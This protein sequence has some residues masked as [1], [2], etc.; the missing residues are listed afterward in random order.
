MISGES[1]RMGPGPI[2]PFF[3]SSPALKHGKGA[4]SGSRPIRET[5]TSDRALSAFQVPQK[6]TSPGIQEMCPQAGG[7]APSGAVFNG[8]GF[9]YLILEYGSAT[10]STIK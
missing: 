1:A 3:V 2:R 4:Q 6:D 7:P 8:T 5:T 10:R 9:S